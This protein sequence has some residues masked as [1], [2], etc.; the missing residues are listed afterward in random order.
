MHCTW[1][2][3]EVVA[4]HYICHVIYAVNITELFFFSYFLFFELL[5]RLGLSLYKYS[6]IGCHVCTYVHSEK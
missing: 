6:M 5:N 4:S 2:E 1:V 3:P